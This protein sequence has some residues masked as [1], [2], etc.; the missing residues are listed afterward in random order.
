MKIKIGGKEFELSEEQLKSESVELTFDGTLRTAEE[1][2]TFIENHK[3]EARKEGEELV[4][5]KYR[6]EYGFQGR[7][8]EKLIEA[9]KSKTLEEA[10]VEPNEKVSKLE[11]QLEEKN[12]ALELVN[13]EKEQAISSF[14]KFKTEGLIDKTLES[15][16]PEKT[17]L[18]KDDMKLL[19]KNKFGFNLDENGKVIVSDASGNVIKNPTTAD[20]KDAKSIVDDFFRE[21]PT[22]ISGVQGGNGGGDSGGK[23]GKIGLDDFIK[24]QKEAGINP[25]S[26]EFNAKLEEAT[27][28]NL[29]DLDA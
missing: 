15:L 5:K 12:K 20:P 28:G 29:I 10:K 18:P 7:T 6:D 24:Q 22:Y 26:P 16:L 19:L 4:V 27:K 21:N 13:S 1:E 8:V 25:N 9:V 17:I 14:N 3:K 2:A 23:G 11:K